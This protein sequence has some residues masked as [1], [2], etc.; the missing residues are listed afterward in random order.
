MLRNALL[1]G[2]ALAIAPAALAQTAS[3][4]ATP[5]WPAIGSTAP[6][7]TLPNLLAEDGAPV[8]LSEV[9]AEKPYAAIIWHS[10]T[11]PFVLP[12][13][14]VLPGMAEQYG[15][16]GVQFIAINSNH[17]E[18]DEQVREHLTG[19][20]FNF[21]VLRDE[22][23]VIADEYGAQN[24]PEVFLVGAGRTLLYHGQISDN[25]SGPGAG[26]EPTL[27]NV[28][29]AVLAG[30]QPPVTETPHRGCTVHRVRGN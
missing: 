4:E 19:A 18:T 15:E 9:L 1:V 24:T 23:N 3:P 11:C 22:G 14:S 13:D 16:Q 5:E 27:A 20:G 25:S 17:D 21:P 30:E 2:A 7:F 8:T 6:D 26:G 28:L 10:V 12:Y 29:S